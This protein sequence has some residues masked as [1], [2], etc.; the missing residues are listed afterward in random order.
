MRVLPPVEEEI[1][2][3]VRD[4]RAG[5]PVIRVAGLK[6]VLQAHFGPRVFNDARAPDQHPLLGTHRDVNEVAKNI[7]MM[8]LAPKPPPACT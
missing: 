3:L 5:D 4:A 8:D 2:R 7:V 1:R 6:A